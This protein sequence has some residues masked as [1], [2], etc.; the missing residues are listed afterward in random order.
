LQ[1]AIDVAQRGRRLEPDNSFYDWAL[2]Y[3][4]FAG[5]RDAEAYRVLEE[6][7]RKPRYDDHSYDEAISAIAAHEKVRPLL[8]EE[9]M[10]LSSE[11]RFLQFAKSRELARLVSWQMW[12]AEKRGDHARAIEVRFNFAR[13]CQPMLQ[14]RNPLI[15]GLVGMACRSIIWS[16]NRQR[17]V[18]NNQRPP[19]ISDANWFILRS[20][21]SAQS[22]ANYARTHGRADL[23][24]ETMQMG[25]LQGRFHAA[26]TS[27]FDRQQWYGFPPNLMS[28]IL[29]LTVLSQVSLI[30]MVALLSLCF[31]VGVLTLFSQPAPLQ[32]H[33]VLTSTLAGAAIAALC[34]VIALRIVNDAHFISY[35]MQSPGSQPIKAVSCA[36]IFALAPFLGSVIVPWGMTLWRMWQQ[37]TELFAPPPVRYEGESARHITRDYLSFALTLCIWTLGI[38]ALGCWI[39]ALVALITNATSWTLPFGSSA[40][41]PPITINEP[42]PV[43]TAIAAILMIMLYIG[44]LIKWRWFAPVKLRPLLHSALIWHRQTLLSYLIVSSLFYLLLSVAAL[45]PRRE[46]DARF[47]DYL[48]RGEISSLN[49]K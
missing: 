17:R 11:I 19:N 38:I 15:T 34:A 21:K 26:T 37:R 32:R 30:Q 10:N 36:A 13:L 2:M 23:V 44:W 28:R 20:R 42:A 46:A 40:G 5:Y 12:K 31:F 14:G 3:F 49:L 45:E 33:D 25:E 35:V 29:G 48:Q 47:N 4:Y 16:G 6:G 8:W 27:V 24:P 18:R 7:S 22:F 41:Q 43:F 9:K 39:A 1:Q